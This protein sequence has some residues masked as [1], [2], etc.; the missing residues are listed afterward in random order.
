V[1]G[2]FDGSAVFGDG[3]TN[4]TTLVSA[5]GSG[6]L[7]VAKYHPNGQLVW[8]KQAG[9]TEFEIA[10][11]IALDGSGN[12]TLTGRFRGS[13]LFG[14]AEANETT[15]VST[16]NDDVFVA[17]YDP[18][19]Q[20]VWATRAG[21]TSSDSGVAV[22]V[23]GDGASAVT[24]SFLGSAVF[25]DGEAN[26]TTLVGAGGF[27]DIFVAK[28]SSD[29]DGD[30]IRD[31]EDNCLADANPDQ[32]DLD[33]DGAGDVCDV[34]AND[35]TDLCDPDRSG[36]G[37]VD[38]GGGTVCNGDESICL[39][40]PPDA[41]PGD[42]SISITDSG[43]GTL[44]ELT[45]N[46]G[47]GTALFEV[48]ID[49]EGLQFDVPVAITFTWPDADDDG[50]I[51][52]TNI[53]EE[54]VVITKDDVAITGRCKF[55]PGC[56]TAANTF[57]VQVDSL[58]SFTVFDPDA[59][60]AL[61]EVKAFRAPGTVRLRGT[62]GGGKSSLTKTL[63]VVARLVA[64]TAER[65]VLE[66]ARVELVGSGGQAF[67]FREVQTGDLQAGGGGTQ[68]RFSVPFDASG[69]DA[70]PDVGGDAT[71]GVV[72]FVATVQVRSSAASIT[73]PKMVEMICKP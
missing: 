71:T 64:G 6:D 26:E 62:A 67:A 32:A 8:A 53:N 37:S 15:L 9:G 1:T 49:P 72:N 48:T 51:D 4:E 20:L 23:D 28:F 57:V 73:A 10:F 17:K 3:E 66:R 38:D 56:D 65:K 18:S 31:P 27:A 7:F 44:F 11:G 68:F 5:G 2:F 59:P 14:D 70:L 36:G 60:A 24:G 54:N 34:C 16:G 12:S 25:G 43:M 13:A 52:G 50:R 69:C 22:A 33:G 63:T 40:I 39:D 41:L 19:G 30:G 55:E 47:N 42:T 58:S 61:P 21:G 35:P 29:T 45:T 46:L